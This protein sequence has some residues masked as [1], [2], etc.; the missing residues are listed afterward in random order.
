MNFLLGGGMSAPC[1][2]PLFAARRAIARAEA[3]HARTNAR[4]CQHLQTDG[5]NVVHAPHTKV[6]QEEG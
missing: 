1:V 6:E 2:E 4:D 5:G 3:R